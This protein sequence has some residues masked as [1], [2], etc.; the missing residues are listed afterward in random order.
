MTVTRGTFVC[1]YTR[2]PRTLTLE[3][4]MGAAQVVFRDGLQSC[5]RV[6]PTAGTYLHLT[7]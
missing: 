7:N 6:A 4:T 2:R 1:L 5:D 3:M